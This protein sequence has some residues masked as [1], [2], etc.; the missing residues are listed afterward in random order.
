MPAFTAPDGTRLAYHVKGE[1]DPVLVVP[2]GAMRASAYL[3][4]LGGLTGQRRLI[5]LDLRGTGGSAVPADPTTYR[6]DRLAD[7][8]EA[9]R[10]HLGLER[11]DLLAHS[12]GASVALLYAAGR[13]ERVARLGLITPNGRAIGMARTRD[14]WEEA[15]RL[16]RDEPWFDAA[17]AAVQAE[18]A[19]EQEVDD[20]LYAPFFYGRWDDRARAHF[21]AGEE[22]TNDEA[23]DLYHAEGMRDPSAVRAALA[24]LDAPVLVLAGELDGNPRPARARRIADVFPH[25]DVAV[26]PGAGHHPWLDD[27]AWF[28]DRVGAFFAA[29]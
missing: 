2:G 21:A 14:D 29:G 19:G 26:Q 28:L 3:E 6:C 11:V 25:A 17:Y 24:R 27:P 10:V 13:P 22:E 16:R 1:G 4:D 7:D 15:M 23:A 5:F 20:M 9:L 8:V 18:A 12:A